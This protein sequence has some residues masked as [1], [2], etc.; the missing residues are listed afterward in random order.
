[1]SWTPDS[2]KEFLYSFN[3]TIQTFVDSISGSP[4]DKV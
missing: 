2:K 1:M 3:P 4:E